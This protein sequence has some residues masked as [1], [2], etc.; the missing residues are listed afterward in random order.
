[1]P[2]PPPLDPRESL[3][4]IPAGDFLAGDAHGDPGEEPHRAHVDAFA[5]M[6]TEVTHAQFAR[7]VAAT[8]H[9]T[10]AERAGRGHIWWHHDAARPHAYRWEGPRS[11]TASPAMIPPLRSAPA[12]ARGSRGRRRCC[13][14]P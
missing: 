6:R 9:L 7:F 3:V 11:P 8:G 4:A 10:H 1:T 14:P 2:P 5:L 12:W 13:A